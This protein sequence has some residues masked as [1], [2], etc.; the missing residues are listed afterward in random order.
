MLRSGAGRPGN[1]YR[2]RNRRCHRDG[3]RRADAFG[4]PRR[5][6]RTRHRTR[7]A[8]Q[9]ALNLGWAIGYNAIALPI[10]AGVFD[11]FGLVLRPEIAAISM[12]GSSFLVATNAVLLKRLR[13]PAAVETLEPGSHHPPKETE[14][15]RE[16]GCPVT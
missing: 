10:A 3:R 15:D 11:A 2:R 6:H 7:G 9:D 13:L 8:T 4:S 12:S 14:D 5:S 1:R 16:M